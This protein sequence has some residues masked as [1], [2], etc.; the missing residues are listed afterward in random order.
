M[1]VPL[2]GRL[3]IIQMTCAGD[4]LQSGSF[5]AE[6]SPGSP[7][8]PKQLQTKL[9]GREAGERTALS[10]PLG[11][12]AVRGPCTRG[13]GMSGSRHGSKA[14]LIW[15]ASNPC[16][17]ALPGFPVKFPQAQEAG[18][19]EGSASHTRDDAWLP[20]FL[21]TAGARADRTRGVVW[22]RKRRCALHHP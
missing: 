1:A 17:H 13:P 10:S 11:A 5:G 21:F 2:S 15:V 20:V 22:P 14:T 9:V 7:K 19:L 18:S 8:W 16:V 6:R 4:A 3:T 12:E